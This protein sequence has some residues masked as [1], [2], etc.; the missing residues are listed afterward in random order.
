[1]RFYKRAMRGKLVV[2]NWKMNGSL[3]QNDALLADLRSGWTAMPSRRIAICVPF[4]YLWQAQAALSGSV[5]EWGAQNVSEHASG[6]FTGE[7]AATMVAEFGSRVAIVGHSERRALYGETDAAV[8]NKALAALAA[9]LTPIVCVGETLAEREAS[10]T[11]AVVLRQLD[12]VVAV[13]GEE[14]AQA[15]VAYEPVW[16]IG[17]GRTAT[18]QQA[19]AVHELLRRRLRTA[20]GEAADEMLLLYGGSVKADNA[21]TLFA[22]ANIDGGLVGGASLKADEFLAIARA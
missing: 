6:A 12:A 5:V 4:P 2:G 22:C 8:A 13:L 3:R 16:A 11:D 15:V 19:E 20:V 9:G 14:L 1:M 10:A 17:T 7:V 18:P 21:K